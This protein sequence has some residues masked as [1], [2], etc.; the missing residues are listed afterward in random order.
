[1]KILHCDSC[2]VEVNDYGHWYSGEKPRNMYELK[3]V[4]E[5]DSN[6]YNGMILC[7]ECITKLLY[8]AESRET[9][10]EKSAIKEKARLSHAESCYLEQ[11]I[12][13]VL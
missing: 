11:G 1:M 2:H 6:N 3:C 12:T 10:G 9:K 5:S 7:H 8:K 13:Q 4:H